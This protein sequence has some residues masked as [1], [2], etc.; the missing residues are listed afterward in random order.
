MVTA[1]RTEIE[2]RLTPAPSMSR[3][4]KMTHSAMH[5]DALVRGGVAALQSKARRSGKAS[6]TLAEIID[7]SQLDSFGTALPGLDGGRGKELCS[8]PRGH[9]DLQN[10]LAELLVTE[11]TNTF[12]QK[13]ELK[14]EKELLRLAAAE[15]A[16][17]AAAAAAAAGAADAKGAAPP[18]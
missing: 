12:R 16:A 14:G 4:G 6:I 1:D 17:A 3:T 18:T 10:K 15:E 13:M 5:T 2:K 9:P 8:S 11:R 7:P